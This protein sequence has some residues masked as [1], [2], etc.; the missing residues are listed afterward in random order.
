MNIALAYPYGTALVS[1][2][3]KAQAADFRVVENLGF[4]P[5]G[6][7][8]H[9]FL[10]VKKSGL[11]SHELIDALAR[12]FKLKPRDIGYS[13]LKDKLAVT[14]QWLSLHMPGQ[15]NQFEM[16]EISGY[17]VLQQGWHHRKLKPGTHRTNS[18]EVII[19]NLEGFTE[20]SSRQIDS[21]KSSGMANYFGQQRFGERLDNVSRAI[22][23]F[24]NPRKTR[25]LSRN[26][27]S[28]YL[29]AL[30]SHLFNQVLSSRIE[31]G[32][33]QQPVEGD[34]F[35][36]SGSQSNFQE[37]LSDDIQSRYQSF[38]LSSSASLF[39]EGNSKLA[40]QAA[41]IENRVFSE[42][43]EI[44]ESLLRLKAKLQM[45]PIRV[46]VEDLNVEYQEKEKTL[47]IKATL[48]SGSYFTT[49]L[50]HFIDIQK[51]S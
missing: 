25:K 35:M 2:T 39:G 4:E 9:L 17:T 24:S 30:R 49:L 46:A 50:N 15:M 6:E 23:A 33:W 1:G 18:F 43:S 27:R 12:D 36:L 48:P 51:E 29:S 42:H 34:V 44:V 13:G 37:A 32:H 31:S 7:G 5:S 22:Q 11:S 3:I 21:I 47:L 16:P 41:A 20:H 8:E 26:K 40:D 14:Q 10:L 45:R 28:L 19:R 38:D